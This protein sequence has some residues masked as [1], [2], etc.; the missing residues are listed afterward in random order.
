MTATKAT[1]KSDQ[2]VV[3]I[4]ACK[5]GTLYTGITNDLPART[6]AHNAGQGA[7]YTRPMSRRPIIIVYSAR[8]GSQS[9]AAREEARIKKMSRSDKN[10]LLTNPRSS[11]VT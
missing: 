9:D 6:V 4:A 11:N 7:K 8:C 2:W 10:F 1:D 3:Y 5:D